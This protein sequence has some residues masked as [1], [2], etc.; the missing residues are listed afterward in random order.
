MPH[1]SNLFRAMIALALAA[2]ATATAIA[3][4]VRLRAAMERMDI[5]GMRAAAE[6]PAER[7]LV[8]AVELSW[9]LR[10]DE[11]EAAFPTAIG[12]QADNVLRAAALWELM[13][14]RARQGEFTAAV[15]AGET[16][17][18]IAPATAGQT[19][20]LAFMK[21]L[22]SVVPTRALGDASGSAPITRD[23]AGLRRADITIGGVT[24]GTVLDTGANFS[25]INETLAKRM[26]LVMLDAAVSVGS[27]SRDAVASRLGVAERLTIGDATFANVVF[28]VLPDADLSFANG[29]YTID[30]IL[31]MPVFFEMERIAFATVDGK[32]TF[33][34][35]EV[36]P[37]VGGAG[38]NILY[39]GFS[40]L[41]DLGVTVNGAPQ[42]LSLLLDSGAQQTSLSARVAAEHPS[43]LEGAA[44]VTTQRGGAGGV[45]TSDKTRRIS[46][47]DAM[48]G[49]K[50]VVLKDLDVHADVEEDRHGILGLDA[51]GG[52]F[53]IDW[54]AGVLVAN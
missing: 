20:A 22:A 51:L 29:A 27:S 31:G 45:V 40:P 41:I 30:A 24:A 5:A 14:L 50:P 3:D 52:G 25:T 12:T 46:S 17:S 36:A 19:Q 47:L 6:T 44:I 9:T 13:S 8:E 43:L 4:P 49:G 18:Q 35:G 53:T 32:E 7:K 54:K 26:G 42:R 15:S 1:H 28:I 37:T 2:F 39:N 11:A 48:V 34:F 21:G 16:A 33:L 10:D 23:L 38:R